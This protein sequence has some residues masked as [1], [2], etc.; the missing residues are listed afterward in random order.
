MLEFLVFSVRIENVKSAVLPRKQILVYKHTENQFH[1][2]VLPGLAHNRIVLSSANFGFFSLLDTKEIMHFI[3][4][5]VIHTIIAFSDTNNI[6]V[7]L[8]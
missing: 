4:H 7:S 1:F 3:A 8:K 2:L 5:T 6:S